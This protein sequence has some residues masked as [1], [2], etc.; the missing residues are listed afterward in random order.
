MEL[1]IENLKHI[2][3]LNVRISKRRLIEIYFGSKSIE[4]TKQKH[5][6]AQ[7]N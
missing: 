7:E 3:L 5:N 1:V 4:I 2:H 6:V